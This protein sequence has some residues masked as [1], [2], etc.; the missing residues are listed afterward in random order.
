MKH[1]WRV[2]SDLLGPESMS[3]MKLREASD[4]TWCCS[5]L[6][7]QSQAQH[8][9][10]SRPNKYLLNKL[11][12]EKSG[13]VTK[14]RMSKSECQAGFALYSMNDTKSSEN[15]KKNSYITE[16]VEILSSAAMCRRL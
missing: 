15:C 16:C 5:C 12:E 10:Q 14:V 11:T 9:A 3:P 13:N 2:M 7:P 1:I 4:W 8:L 6:Y